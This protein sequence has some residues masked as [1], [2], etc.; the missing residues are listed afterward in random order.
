MLTFP[1]KLGAGVCPRFGLLGWMFE[2]RRPTGAERSDWAAEL[3]STKPEKDMDAFDYFLLSLAALV[4][5]ELAAS[6]C[7]YCFEWMVEHG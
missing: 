2:H 7:F 3:N 6:L 1:G 5:F 4:A